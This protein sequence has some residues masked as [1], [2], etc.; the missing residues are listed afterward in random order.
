MELEKG[1][2]FTQIPWQIYRP[3]AIL[4]ELYSGDY[5]LDESD[6]TY[7]KYYEIN[8]KKAKG[9]SC[10]VPL[11]TPHNVPSERLNGPEI[12]YYFLPEGSYL[13]EGLALI[14][15]HRMKLRFPSG[16]Q[17][18][19][20]FVI[21]PTKRMKKEQYEQTV[22][23]LDWQ[24]CTIKVSAE[25][26]ELISRDD[27]LEG[28]EDFRMNELYWLMEI[29]HAQATNAMDRLHANDI[30]TWI[31]LDKPSF[32]DLILHEARAYIVFSILARM[33]SSIPVTHVT[34]LMYLGDILGE[35]DAFE[36]KK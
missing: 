29:W 12:P 13:S 11:E 35:L 31:S 21:A 28:V 5:K 25:M 33:N 30:H 2:S 20:H 32:Q 22:K 36:W 27:D 8:D 24:L 17:G 9:V 1:S 14:Y 19:L 6:N 15:T 10:F 3:N 34:E 23:E 4:Q 7:I 16:D 18:G 26:D